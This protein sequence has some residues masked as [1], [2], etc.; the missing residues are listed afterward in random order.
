MSTLVVQIPERRRP[1]A[2]RRPESSGLGTEYAYVSTS[3]GLTMT[4]Q[5][6]CGRGA[7]A[8]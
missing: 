8:G 6:E 1:G 3:D 4:G 2:R 7:A 5:G